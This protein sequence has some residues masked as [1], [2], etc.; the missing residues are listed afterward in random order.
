M[1]KCY[2]Y[3]NCFGKV[4]EQYLLL[5]EQFKNIYDIKVFYIMDDPKKTIDIVYLKNTDLF[6]YQVMSKNAFNKEDGDFYCTE[7]IITLLPFHCKKI[8]I[9]SCY[10][11]GYFIDGLSQNQLPQKLKE[12]NVMYQN[13]LLCEFFP[14]YCFNKKLFNMLS[15]KI[16][17]DLILK[18][19]QSNDFYNNSEIFD[20][21]N[22]SFNRFSQKEKD[23]N[24]DIP[25]T[26]FILQ[27]FK[28]KRLFNTT[29]HPSKFIFEYI[30]TELLNKLNLTLNINPHMYDIDLMKCT[31]RIP[32]FNCIINYLGICTEFNNQFYIQNNLFETLYD[33]ILFY[34]KLFEENNIT[35]IIN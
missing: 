31:G 12:N 6:I 30:I 2:I 29:N 20:C 9:P 26:N 14:N 19:I 18:N 3:A 27:N 33:Y 34:K 22:S 23:N 25:I 16:S 5:I 21:I 7:S 17:I 10:F 32:I 13:K 11:D 4:L 35:E 24:I 28:N 8:S 1:L 15:S